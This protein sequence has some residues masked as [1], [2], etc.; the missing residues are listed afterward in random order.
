MTDLRRLH[1]AL[2]FMFFSLALSGAF[3]AGPVWAEAALRPVPYAH[4]QHDLDAV[5]TFETLPRWAEPGINLDAPMREGRVWLGERLSGQTVATENTAHDVLAGQPAVPL[6]VAPGATGAN[7]SV[8]YHRGFGSNALFPLGPDGFPALSARGEGALAILFDQDQRAIG[9]RIHSDYAAPL[10]QARP[11]GSVTLSFYTRQGRL[12]AR[13]VQRLGRT[14]NEI[15]FER[16]NDL[17]DIA[18]V[19]VTNDDPGG[20]ALDDILYQ[21]APAAF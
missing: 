6:A 3:G 5:I 14:I 16:S 9:L 1:S 15:G 18:A 7:L 12:I 4:L 11:Q 2:H 8:A 13:H 17:P 19:T 20:I 21:T 10:G